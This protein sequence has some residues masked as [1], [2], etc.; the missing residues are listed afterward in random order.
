MS[1]RSRRNRTTHSVHALPPQHWVAAPALELVHEV[2]GRLLEMLTRLAGHERTRSVPQIVST[3]REQWRRFDTA[4]RERAARIPILLADIHF[5][6]ED[7]WR[8]ARNPQSGIR[9]SPT[10]RIR[11]PAKPAGELMRETL[12]LGLARGTPRSTCCLL[13]SWDVAKRRRDDCRA[14]PSGARAN[15]RA[16]QPPVASSVGRCPVVLAESPSGRTQR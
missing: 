4:A 10:S 16:A 6:D 2:N 9:H 1:L 7:W 5:Q 11:F 12:T 3:H 15:C 14:R 8:W 13:A